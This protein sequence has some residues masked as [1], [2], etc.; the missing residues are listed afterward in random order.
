MDPIPLHSYITNFSPNPV[1][2]TLYNKD[3]DELGEFLGIDIIDGYVYVHD[4]YELQTKEMIECY[5]MD[6]I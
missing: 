1:G 4:G 6:E 3:Q 2:I 5:V